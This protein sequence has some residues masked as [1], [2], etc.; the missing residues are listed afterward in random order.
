METVWLAVLTPVVLLIGILVT[1]R[2]ANKSDKAEQL[3]RLARLTAPVWLPEGD[4]EHYAKMVVDVHG[5]LGHWTSRGA[6][7]TPGREHFQA[8]VAIVQ[9]AFRNRLAIRSDTE[10][11]EPVSRK[12]LRKLTEAYF[13]D[14][15][16]SQDGVELPEDGFLRDARNGSLWQRL[17]RRIWRRR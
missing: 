1:H 9:R 10:G 4:R 16:G 17:W 14:R 11:S 2:R 7:W 6:F 8:A 15:T 5:R 3:E 12:D 13:G